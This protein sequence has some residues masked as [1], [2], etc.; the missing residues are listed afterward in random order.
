[1]QTLGTKLV[2]YPL[3]FDEGHNEANKTNLI[4]FESIGITNQSKFALNPSTVLDKI[5]TCT[6]STIFHNLLRSLLFFS[7][8]ILFFSFFESGYSLPR[9]QIGYWAVKIVSL[10]SKI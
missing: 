6:S 2:I 5:S 1:M 4:K 10:N 8:F 9:D 3:N 7:F